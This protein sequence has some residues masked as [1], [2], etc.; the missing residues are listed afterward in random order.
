MAHKRYY[1]L[2][3]RILRHPDYTPDDFL[4]V[5]AHR[6]APQGL[7]SLRVS[8]LAHVGRRFFTLSHGTEIPLHRI[9][10]IRNRRTGEILVG[11]EQIEGEKEQF[12]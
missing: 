11:D 3:N 5:Y 9:V 10:Q 12:P 6:G 4:I 1:E 2:L 7:D 8:E